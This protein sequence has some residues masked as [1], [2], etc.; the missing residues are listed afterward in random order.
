VPH[1]N[2]R[3]VERPLHAR[4]VSRRP[5]A[6]NEVFSYSQCRLARVSQ[7]SRIQDGLHKRRHS[8]TIMP[9]TG[10]NGSHARLRS[11]YG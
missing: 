3:I 9:A 10:Q 11:T 1:A 5:R 6:K 2:V 4:R 7:G 8:R